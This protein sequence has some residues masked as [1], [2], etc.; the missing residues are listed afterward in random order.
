M[1]LATGAVAL[2][3]LAVN[4]EAFSPAG[5]TVQETSLLGFRSWWLIETRWLDDVFVLGDMHSQSLFSPSEFLI[6]PLSL[7]LSMMV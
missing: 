4:T 6:P 5:E 3:Y 2:W 7:T 1:K